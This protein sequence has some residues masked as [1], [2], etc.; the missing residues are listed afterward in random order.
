MPVHNKLTIDEIINRKPEN[1]FLTPLSIAKPRLL[2]CG[3]NL[4]MLRCVCICGKKVKI[5]LSHFLNGHTKSCGCRK[6]HFVKQ[7]RTKYIGNIKGIYGSYKKMISR[8]YNQKDANYKNYGRRGVSVCDEWRN[9]YQKFLDWSLVNGWEPGL[10]IDKDIKGNGLLYSP[11]TCRWVTS[12]ENMSCTSRTVNYDYNGENINL[13]E[14]S[15]IT[16]VKLTTLAGRV[17]NMGLSIEEAVSR[18]VDHP[19]RTKGSSNKT[20]IRFLYKGRFLSARNICEA[21]GISWEVMRTRVRRGKLTVSDL[22]ESICGSVIT[23]TK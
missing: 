22:I 7:A 23:E 14:I 5:S 13:P 3:E 1:S 11:S 16:G 12:L 8:C 15:R 6:R 10:E 4:S 18:P 19:H 17:K 2:P 20:T 9:D 21:E